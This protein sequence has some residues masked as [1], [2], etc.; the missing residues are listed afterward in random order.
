MH[1]LIKS[2][3]MKPIIRLDDQKGEKGEERKESGKGNAKE[4][5]VSF[6]AC[7]SRWLLCFLIQAKLF[8]KKKKKEV[9]FHSKKKI[10]KFRV[11][12]FE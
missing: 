4:A 5:I 2:M 11:K 6:A 8:V 9:I 1:A 3:I 10:M 7:V 12:I